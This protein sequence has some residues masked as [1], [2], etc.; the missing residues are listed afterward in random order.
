[1]TVAMAAMFPALPRRQRYPLPPRQITMSLA[2][3]AGVARHL[4]ESQRQAVTFVAHFAYGAAMGALYA[5]LAARIAGPPLLKGPAFGIAVW[6]G[7][8][9][10][11]LPATN[12]LSPATRHAAARNALMITAHL[13]WGAVAGAVTRFAQVH[14]DSRHR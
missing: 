14:A 7:S 13:V 2:G 5:P 12:T 1:M 8:Y 11:W 9:L 3:K 4:N 10:G 6:A